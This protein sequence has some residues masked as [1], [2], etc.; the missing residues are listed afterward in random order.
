MKFLQQAR[1]ARLSIRAW[2]LARRAESKMDDAI[3]YRKL[4]VECAT[5]AMQCQTLATLALVEAQTFSG[6][7]R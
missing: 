3:F 2:R 6:V 5:E 7:T 4:A 1:L